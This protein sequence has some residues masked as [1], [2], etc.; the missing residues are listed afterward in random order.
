VKIGG[1]DRPQS[2]TCDPLEQPLELA[3]VDPVALHDEA[4]QGIVHQLGERASGDV[5]DIPPGYLAPRSPFIS[6][7]Q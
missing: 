5:H 1:P 3:A 4:D 2:L 7:E 6:N